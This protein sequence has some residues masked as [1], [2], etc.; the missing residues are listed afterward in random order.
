MAR[1]PN[2]DEKKTSLEISL[3]PKAKTRLGQMAKALGLSRSELIEQWVRQESSPGGNAKLL[4]K[5]LNNFK[6]CNANIL[7]I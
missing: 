5:F 1:H 6:S 3:T 2:Y 7:N 4:G